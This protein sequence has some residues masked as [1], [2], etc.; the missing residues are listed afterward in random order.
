MKKVI[1]IV[2]ICILLVIAGWLTFR[3]QYGKMVKY[4]TEYTLKDIDL[5]SIPD[6]EYKGQ[7]SAFLVSVDLNVKVQNH[8]ISDIVIVKQSSG[9]GYEGRSVIDRIL[10]EQSLKVDAKTGAT[11]SSKCILIAVE[12]A[13]TS[14]SK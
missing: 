9:K 11:G 3:F 12:K 2:G 4:L 10:K 13:L 6:G 14:S 1:I 7:S 5:N 8:K